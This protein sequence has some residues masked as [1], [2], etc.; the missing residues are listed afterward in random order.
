[1]VLVQGEHIGGSWT[2]SYIWNILLKQEN[3]SW[4]TSIPRTYERGGKKQ[5]GKTQTKSHCKLNPSSVTCNQEGTQPWFSAW[6]AKGLNWTSGTLTFK[7]YTWETKHPSL[8]A[9]G[10]CIL[11][12]S[13]GNHKLRNNSKGIFSRLN[14]PRLSAETAQ[15]SVKETF[16][17]ILK[18]QL[19]KQVSNLT[20]I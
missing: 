6:G 16:L 19:E 20:D 14:I 7:T 10:T 3:T 18:L 1:M 2:Y 4:A 11:Q 13:Q 15:S 8:K 17:L 5:V 9:T 12:D